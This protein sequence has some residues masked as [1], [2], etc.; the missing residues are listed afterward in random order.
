MGEPESHPF[1]APGDYY[2]EDGCCEMCEVPFSYAPELFGACLGP[3]GDA[4]CFVKRQPK[5]GAEEDRMILA[6]LHAEDGCI[7]YRGRD[8]EVQR[9]LVEAGEGQVCTDLIADLKATSERVLGFRRTY[10]NWKFLG[11]VLP[12]GFMLGS[13]APTWFVAMALA[14]VLGIPDNA[15]VRDQ[16]F[17]FLWF[18]MFIS[19]FWVL[20]LVGYSVGTALNVLILRYAFGCS[21][22]VL[23]RDNFCPGWLARWFESRPPVRAGLDGGRRGGASMYDRDLDGSA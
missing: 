14:R 6:I 8:R 1:N 15:P 7:R 16:P 22:A 4:H 18:V 23:G 10:K 20:M 5:S 11:I 12:I 9:R 19:L 17:G 13:F 21:L 2:V 3:G